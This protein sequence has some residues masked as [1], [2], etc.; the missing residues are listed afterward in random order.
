MGRSE[1]P[2]HKISKTT[3]CK[4]DLGPGFS[5]KPLASEGA[6][7]SVV[8]AQPSRLRPGAL[9]GVLDGADG[10]AQFGEAAQPAD[11]GIAGIGA[12][13]LGEIVEHAMAVIGPEHDLVAR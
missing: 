3:P 1:R 11:R 12:L 7:W 5:L 8:T 13:G 6:G 10:A 9:A 2:R 4:V